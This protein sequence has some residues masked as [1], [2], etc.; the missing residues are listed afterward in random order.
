MLRLNMGNE[1]FA[2]IPS[3]VVGYP[4]PAV[5]SQH[6]KQAFVGVGHLGREHAGSN[7]NWG[8]GNHSLNVVMC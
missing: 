5:A 1:S 7:A 2:A 4:W 6:E 8:I 3:N